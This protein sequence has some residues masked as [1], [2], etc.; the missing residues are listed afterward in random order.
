MPH[1]HPTRSRIVVVAFA[2]IVAATAQWAL[3]FPASGPQ[4]QEAS[5]EVLERGRQVYTRQ[6]QSCHG[7]EGR[8]DGPA[9]RFLEPKPRDLKSG[10]WKYAEGGTVESVARVVR[11][12]ADDTGMTPFN[13]TLSEEQITAVATYVVHVL[14]RPESEAPRP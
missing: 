5:E 3:P 12:G 6:C 7:R 4:D 10:E 13:E 1:Q 11:E 9:A 14:A 2:V 8:G